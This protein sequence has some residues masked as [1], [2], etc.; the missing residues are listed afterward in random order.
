VSKGKA[1][2]PDVRRNPD[3]T[4]DEVVVSLVQHFHLEQMSK[5]GWWMGLRLADGREVVINL[6]SKKRISCSVE[7]DA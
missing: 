2:A 5:G 3:G 1:L 7:V 6:S 4:V